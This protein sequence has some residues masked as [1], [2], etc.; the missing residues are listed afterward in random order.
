MHNPSLPTISLTHVSSEWADLC[1]TE[2]LGD[3]HVY[4][5]IGPCK[6]MPLSLTF[7]AAVGI[8]PMPTFVVGDHANVVSPGRLLNI[9]TGNC[10]EHIPPSANDHLIVVASLPT[11]TVRTSVTASAHAC[12]AGMEDSARA[13]LL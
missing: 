2:V 4:L 5:P 3:S 1:S 8:S 12:W 10:T 7:G 9:T 11:S 13:W 6:A